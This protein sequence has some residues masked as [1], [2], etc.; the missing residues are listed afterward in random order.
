MLFPSLLSISSLSTHGQPLYER[1]KSH[2]AAAQ[3]WRTARG[4]LGSSWNLILQLLDDL[5]R[6]KDG[7]G[8][9][10][11]ASLC[12]CKFVL[13]QV[14]AHASIA[15][16]SRLIPYHRDRR[17]L[18][19]PAPADPSQVKIST[20]PT[21]TNTN[22]HTGKKKRKKKKEAAL[23]ATR[24]FLSGWGLDFYL[25]I[26]HLKGKRAT[27]SRMWLREWCSRGPFTLPEVAPKAF[28]KKNIKS[29]PIS[30]QAWICSKKEWA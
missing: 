21:Q 4:R 27:H 20:S 3:R 30:Q 23:P 8:F 22:K 26:L 1:C 29:S 10:P 28:G 12:S 15:R 18:E 19:E 7:T 17:L 13:M 9:V 24:H 11:C 25:L 14:C 2:S 16:T 6:H 5:S